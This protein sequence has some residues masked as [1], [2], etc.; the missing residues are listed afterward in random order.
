MDP[1]EYGTWFTLLRIY[2]LMSIPS[3]GLQ[4]VFAQQTA[5]AV[6]E[7]QTRQ[8]ARTLRSVLQA[9]LLL[10]LVMGVV[11][12]AGQK[13]WIALLKISN[14]A[15]LW[16]T[17][18][19]GLASLWAPLLK[20]VLQGQQNFLGLGWVLI[21]DGVGRF[22]AIAVLLYLGG[23]AAGGMTGALI[24]QGCSFAAGAW[25]ARGLLRTRGAPLAWRPWLRRVVPLTVGVGSIQFLSNADVVY[26]QT[27]FGDV[28]TAC[29]Y[30]P[31]AMIGL[32][33]VTFATPLAAVMFPKVVRSEAL[34]HD[35]QAGRLALGATALLG[36][37]IA[38]ACTL[39]PRLPL[40]I[41]YSSHPEYW[42][43]AALVPWFA[44]GLLPLI[45][46]NVLISHLLAREKFA[47]VPWVLVLAVGYGLALAFWRKRLPHMDDLTA[48][49]TV[50]GTLGAC[51]LLLFG[52]AA[53]FTW[54]PKART[55]AGEP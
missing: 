34:E 31:A 32:A 13:Q 21:L 54:G 43:A 3:A 35:T 4:I 2:L 19:I 18:A 55:G 39:L 22:A 45:I 12:L 6:T 1:L 50:V 41:I 33:L 14:P 46:A 23:Q 5:A 47:V 10:W 44:W 38:L 26:V 52:V 20:G 9:T 25:W 42:A 24:G 27:V 48:F 7:T 29:G 36:F 40:Q 53:W 49:K 37:G 17:L 30:M 28:R 8:L 51:S 15:A 11:A 16:V